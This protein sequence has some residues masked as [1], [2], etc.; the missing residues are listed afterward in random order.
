M[1]VSLSYP[2]SYLKTY[3][4]C[5][6]SCKSKLPERPIPKSSSSSKKGQSHTVGAIKE[7]IKTMQKAINN[8]NLKNIDDTPIEYTTA[9]ENVYKLSLELRETFEK[10]QASTVE[11]IIENTIE[12]IIDEQQ[13][14]NKSEEIMKSLT[15]TEFVVKDF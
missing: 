5:V 2:K 15:R 12:S 10:I 7:K 8:A 11:P 14:I 3:P 4:R 13:Q 9:W 1:S 6:I